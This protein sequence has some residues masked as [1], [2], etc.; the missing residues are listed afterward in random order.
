LPE[1][2]KRRRSSTARPWHESQA[3][4]R[5]RNNPEEELMTSAALTWVG[6]LFCVTQSAMFSGLNLAMFGVSRLRLKVEVASGNKAARRVLEMRRDSNFLLTTIL[7]GN[8]GINVLLTLLSN[9]VL[10]GV[11]SF[12]FS[13]V[14]ITILGEILPQAYFSRH[15]LKMGAALAP[16]LRLYQFVLY[17]VAKPTAAVLD[18][19]LGKESVEYFRERHL[20]EIIR[21][22]VEADDTE[23][24]NL[25]GLGA[26]NFLALD[27]L[28]VSEEGEVVDP[29][30]IITLPVKGGRPVFP[31]FERSGDDVFLKRVH[32]SGRKWVIITDGQGEPQ[33][34][35]DADA[36]IR[37]CLL[38]SRELE[39]DRY[40]HRPIVVKDSRLPLGQVILRLRP[41]MQNL[42]DDIIKEDIILVWASQRRIITGA[43]VFGRLMRGIVGHSRAESPA[44]PG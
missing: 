19:W 24:D 13:T 43:D 5:C 23:I 9:S 28:L 2:S 37:D 22:H 14:V 4:R 34:V 42:D 17:P 31:P 16:I 30:S 6:I 10:I 3:V 15:A 39:P 44:T 27:D 7:W 35:L 38:E 41:A 36:F 25:E 20:R 21:E 40:C 29:Q 26:M 8:V 11:Q 18:S 12:L 1:F 33:A 32:R